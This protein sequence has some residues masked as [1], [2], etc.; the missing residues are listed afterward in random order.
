MS[1]TFIVLP[2]GTVVEEFDSSAPLDGSISDDFVD[3][4]FGTFDLTGP[5]T[6]HSLGP[7][8]PG[9]PEPSTLALA[10]LGLLGLAGFGSRRKRRDA[11]RVV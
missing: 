7:Q 10:A 4:E 2:D 11:A 6:V 8:P 5:T 1:A 3:P 9:I